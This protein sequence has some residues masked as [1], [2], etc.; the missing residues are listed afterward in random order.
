MKKI[1]PFLVA[2][3]LAAA[4][5][6]AQNTIT[7]LPYAENFDGVTGN[8]N[9]SGIANHVLPAGWGWINNVGSS[10]SYANYPSCYN[11]STYAVRSWLRAAHA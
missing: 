11:S 10:A 3:L 7:T 4:G 9:T 1:L 5:L 6:Q 8:A 2:L